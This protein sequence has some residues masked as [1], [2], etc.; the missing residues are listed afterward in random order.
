VQAAR[1]FSAT[2]QPWFR[3]SGREA[4][5]IGLVLILG[6]FARTWEYG[7]L[8]P[9]LNAD[10]ASIGVEAYDL[11]HFGVDRNGVT[12]PV[13]FIAWGSGQ[14][15][16][17]GY[18]LIPFIAALGLTPL[19]VRLPM[20]LTGI[21]SLPIMYLVGARTFGHR[22][23]LLA[24][25]FLAVSPWHILLSRWA[26]ESNLLPFVFLTAYAS[27]LL[28]LMRRPWFFVSCL[29]F[30]LSLYA[31]GTAYAIVPI[32]VICAL[33]I[34]VRQRSLPRGH[35]AWGAALFGVTALPIGLFVAVNSLG[36][37]AMSFGPF[38]IPRLPAEARY[39]AA[40]VIGQGEALQGIA[41]NLWT[42]LK[43]LA[44]ESDGLIYNVL[45]PFGYFYR[46]G[47]PLAL[48]GI[49]LLA[50]DFKGARRVE[51]RL[52]I[53]WMGAALVLLILQPVNINR[54]NIAFMPLLI[55]AALAVAW[56]GSRFPS[57]T[58]TSVILLLLA[59]AGFSAAYHG[60]SYRQQI[61]YKF[62]EGLLPALAF[63]ES[64]VDTSLC[65]TDEIN[66][67]YVFALFSG[68]T[69]P[70]E[71]VGSVSY[72]DAQAP[73]RE[74]VSFGRYVFGTQHCTGGQGYT[75]LLTTQ[76]IPPRLGNRYL[77]EFFDNF[78]VYYPKR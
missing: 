72:V 3:K 12:Y 25:L 29:L 9:G 18:I 41:V 36:I 50:F 76:E 1:R 55:L 77:Y 33:G 68:H 49:G 56:L 46:V 70:A 22:V 38:T 31:Y 4:I 15:A 23:G 44:T 63:A 45:D 74:V 53:S 64:Q 32:F 16:L 2:F 60:A 65:V 73:F 8:P 28:G 39:Q 75:Y 71:F 7:R 52:L 14:N 40:T 57:V 35:L 67:P 48:L 78:V 20:L 19:A 21:A 10:E 62:H 69:S 37:S 6:V 34:M 59:F 66:M 43:L 13:H 11:A 26:L 5:L 27:L 61:G 17:Y 54:F 47:L 30:G 58:V 51:H 24:M 42:G